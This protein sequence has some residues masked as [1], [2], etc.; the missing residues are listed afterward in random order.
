M[1][2]L[3]CSRENGERKKKS[4]KELKSEK[5][6]EVGDEVVMYNSKLK[7]ILGK[8]KL[9]RKWILIVKKVHHGGRLELE[10]SDGDIFITND[11]QVKLFHPT[12]PK[13]RE[14]VIFAILRR[15]GREAYGLCAKVLGKDDGV[16][17]KRNLLHNSKMHR[18][19][20]QKRKLSLIWG[21]LHM[22]L[23]TIPFSSEP[24][25][26]LVEFA[27]G[28]ICNACADPTNAAVIIQCDDIPLVIECVSSPIRNTVNYALGSLYYLCN[29]TT[30]DEILK[31]EIVE[32]IERFATAGSVNTG[33]SNLA[34]AFLDRHVHKLT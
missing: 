3:L 22:I 32:V 28:G 25:E 23:T 15:H 33:F 10:N 9:K 12:I 1:L 5:G 34:Q 26:K 27:V 7:R 17:K 6:F 29:A 11:N 20:K 14:F 30:E 31:P 4:L 19:K 24:N 18:V 16:C 21:T 2:D 8:R 13:E